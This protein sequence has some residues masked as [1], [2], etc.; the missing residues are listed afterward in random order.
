MTDFVTSDEEITLVDNIDKIPWVESQS[1]RRKHDFG[2]KVNFKKKKVK[3][4]AF[5]GF[6][7]YSRFLIDKLS[8]VEQLRDFQ[9]VEMC[10][11][12]YQ[13]NKGASID[14]H[15]DD[16]WLWGERLVTVNL[17]SE[18]C[19]TLTRHDTT[20][21]IIVALPRHSLI[22]LYGEAR[23]KWMHSIAR[24]HISTRRIGITIRELT[25]QFLEGGELESVGRDLLAKAQ[26]HCDVE[27]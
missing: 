17:L 20:D 9:A 13:P 3:Q 2:P 19:Y 18:T 8:E 6:P 14:P 16:F 7:Q 5:K 4:E 23:Y 12:D 10:N 11:L 1:G 24:H 15:F 21:Q 26:L 27:S 25:P 22:V